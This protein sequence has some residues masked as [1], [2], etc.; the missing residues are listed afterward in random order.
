MIK[1]PYNILNVKENA[2]LKEIKE[3]YK[4]IAIQYHPDKQ[5]TGIEKEIATQKFIDANIAYNLLIDETQRNKYDNL[6]QKQ[7]KT[8]FEQMMQLIKSLKDKNITN[9]II[10]QLYQNNK[11]ITDLNNLQENI[12][13]FII[14]DKINPIKIED[15]FVPYTDLNNSNINSSFLIN[16]IQSDNINEL[17]IY[18]EIITTFKEL[19]NN[20][21]KE[22]TVKKTININN[23]IETIDKKYNVPLHNFYILIKNGG[24]KINDLSGDAII[25]IKCKKHKLFKKKEYDI[26]YED[27][28]TLYELFYGFSKNIKYFNDEI[29]KISSN[30]PLEEW[31]FNGSILTIIIKNKGFPYDIDNNRGHLII[32]LT[33]IKKNNFYNLL[34]INFN[35]L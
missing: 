30:K 22:L 6:S 8:F 31:T 28:I 19:Y 16:S 34:K 17:N 26:I 24:N 12:I 23:K 9:D 11:N 15:I 18:G 35:E 2:S 7:Q 21:F 32:N 25:T 27:K 33:L 20:T 14:N 10:K 13:N 29:I 1:N 5:K 3:N 4:K